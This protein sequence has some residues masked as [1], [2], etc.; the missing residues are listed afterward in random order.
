MTARS[1]SRRASIRTWVI[2]RHVESEDKVSVLDRVG[3]DFNALSLKATAYHVLQPLTPAGKASAQALKEQLEKEAAEGAFLLDV[4]RRLALT[5]STDADSGPREGLLA[6]DFPPGTFRP[7]AE[8][9]EEICFTGE[10]GKPLGPIKTPFGYSVLLITERTGCSKDD[11][12]F[13]KLV[14][15]PDGRG[16]LGPSEAKIDIQG[17]LIVAPLMVA[18]GL[19]LVGVFSDI[20]MNP[21]RGLS[22]MNSD[23][24]KDLYDA[25]LQQYTDFSVRSWER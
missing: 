18:L 24:T 21:D 13:N 17:L 4:L 5:N 11:R 25:G 22:V 1:L 14:R 3:R 20:V 6:A 15:S 12:R 8:G 10:I 23:P 19:N 9:L 7:G 16:R 2:R